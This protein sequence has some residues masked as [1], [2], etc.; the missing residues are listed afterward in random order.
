[1]T[2]RWKKEEQY[3]SFFAPCF[4][5]VCTRL[6]FH[7]C[8]CLLNFQLEVALLFSG[9]LVSFFRFTRLYYVMYTI[10][11]RSP[12]HSGN[13]Y[14]HF[15]ITTEGVLTDVPRICDV[16][17][18]PFCAPFPASFYRKAPRAQHSGIGIHGHQKQTPWQGK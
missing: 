8:F 7:A 1:M 12:N 2:N 10:P 13:E 14:L 3:Q 11:T 9:F 5:L 18:K 4:L 16:I 6:S 17:F 15:V